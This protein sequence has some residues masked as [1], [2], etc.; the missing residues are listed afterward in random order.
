M[1]APQ[2]AERINELYDILKNSGSPTTI[3]N[4]INAILLHGD[5]IPVTLLEA[6]WDFFAKQKGVEK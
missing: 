4:K 1:N 6:S 3:A 5:G 2:I